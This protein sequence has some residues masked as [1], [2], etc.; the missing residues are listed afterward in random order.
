MNHLKS[1][2]K[3]LVTYN[4]RQNFNAA[5]ARV[6]K[7]P[8]SSKPKMNP[9][10]GRSRV[11]RISIT[12]SLRGS[13]MRTLKTVN[14]TAKNFVTGNQHKATQCFSVP[15][16]L[17]TQLSRWWSLFYILPIK[18]QK[19]RINTTIVEYGKIQVLAFLLTLLGGREVAC[20]K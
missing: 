2:E 8:S 12:S 3:S 9:K 20:L 11:N 19:S 6:Y 18:H 14:S 7:S 1:I 17:T 5:L 16:A 13:E 4:I 15:I 10:P